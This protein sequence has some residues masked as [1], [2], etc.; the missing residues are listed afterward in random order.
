[1]SEER[2]WW[3]SAFGKG[4][5]PLAALTD[6]PGFRE[7]TRFELP[8]VLR[9]LAVRPGAELLDVCCGVGRHA[10]PLAARGLRVTGLDVSR[11]YLA[12][13]RRR[14]RK[15][16]LALELVR[17]DM[18]RMPFSS[19]F[20]A[21]VNL[22]TSFGYFASAAEDR[23]ALRSIRRALKPGGLFLLD[24]INGGRLAYILRWQRSMELSGEH[25]T[26]LPDGTLILEDPESVDGGRVLR[27]RW[28]FLRGARREE[29]LTRIRLYTARRLTGLLRRAGFEVLRLYGEMSQTPYRE[30]ASR[31][32]VVLARRPR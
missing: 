1:M 10:L 4:V 21:A 27:T 5:Y 31:R 29:L 16:G 24:T 6:S 8:F 13:A 22:W 19:R 11:P 15:A 18:R 2:D 17:G 25:W 3:R 20:D 32:L 30:R 14:A 26:E 12:E 7:R 23:A 9:A 28:L